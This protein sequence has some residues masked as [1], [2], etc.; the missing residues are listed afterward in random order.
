MTIEKF[1][2]GKYYR[3]I[4]PMEGTLDYWSYEMNYWRDKKAHKCL[5]VGDEYRE[6]TERGY[7]LI[8][9][10]IF[11]GIGS[12]SWLYT[13]P[14]RTKFFEEVTPLGGDIVPPVSP[15]VGVSSQEELK[16]RVLGYL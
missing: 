16:N 3:F 11:E 12:S 6:K 9:P 4:G 10:C 5:R 2:V 15:E 8:Q 14:H 7:G 13:T 1:E